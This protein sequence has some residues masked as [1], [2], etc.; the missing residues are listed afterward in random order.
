MYPPVLNDDHLYKVFRNIVDEDIYIE[1]KEPL[2]L[3]EDF[4]FYQKAIPGIFFF[5]GTKCQEYQSGLHTETFNF[6]EEVLEKAIDLYEK[7]VMN[8][9][10]E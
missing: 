1:L 3:A 10:G 2:M 7:I 5:L 9:K 6:H 4:S 8:L